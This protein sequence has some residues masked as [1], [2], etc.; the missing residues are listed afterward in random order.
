MI[1]GGPVTYILKSDHNSIVKHHY[2]DSMKK[3][4]I[5]FFEKIFYKELQVSPKNQKI[6]ICESLLNPTKIRELIAKVL[7]QFF[8]VSLKIF[9]IFCIT[10]VLFNI[11]IFRLLH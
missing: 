2:D 9:Q 8:E 6:I 10:T 4:I 7:F 11:V 1:L 5:K 3:S